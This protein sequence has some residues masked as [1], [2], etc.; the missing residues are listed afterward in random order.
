M[1]VDLLN[2]SRFLKAAE[3]HGEDVTFTIA[4]VE[5]QE[6]EREDNSK[7]RKGLMSFRETP[8][9]LVLN[10]TNAKCIAAMFGNETDAWR[11]KR[12]TFFPA[13][14]KDPFSGEQ[15]TAIRVRGSPDITQPVSATIKL[16]KRKAQTM[17]M[18][19][20]MTRFIAQDDLE[21]EV[22]AVS[23]AIDACATVE[24]LDATWN[25]ALA[26]GARLKALPKDAADAATKRF[27]ERKRTLRAPP[28]PSDQASLPPDAT[29]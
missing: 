13:P 27:V 7:E 9:L 12:V 24:E 29:Q 11:G 4:D 3:F 22:E 26:R 15:I 21:R 17:T 5:L 14:M 1:H 16:R 25:G 19:N 10:R 8:K 18:R 2:P 23:A 20:T 6:L 28:P